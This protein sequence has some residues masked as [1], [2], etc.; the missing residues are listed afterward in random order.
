ML[1]L[2]DANVDAS[3]LSDEVAVPGAVAARRGVQDTEL[4]GNLLRDGRRFPN[5][6]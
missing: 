5:T 2:G 4:G 1:V 6:P 3:Q